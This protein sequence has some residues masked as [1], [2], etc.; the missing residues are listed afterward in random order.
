MTLSRFEYIVWEGVNDL[1]E[2]IQALVRLCK[3]IPSKVN[4]IQ[5]NPIE[6]S[7][8]KQA[9]QTVIDAY[10]SV[11]TKSRIS[12]TYRRSRGLDIDAACGQLANKGDVK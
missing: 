10:I 3:R 6:G 9:N 11:L 4:I 12:V 1:M 8:M 5:Y 7:S 2:D